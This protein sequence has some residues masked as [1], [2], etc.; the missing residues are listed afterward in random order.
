MLLRFLIL[1]A[2]AAILASRVDGADPTPRADAVAFGEAIRPFLR[3][4]CTDCHSGSAAEAGLDLEQLAADLHDPASFSRWVAVHDRLRSGEMPPAEM[5]QPSAQERTSAVALLNDSLHAENIRQ[6]TEHGRVPYRRLNRSAYEYTLRD[7]MHLPH[8]E[9]RAMLPA[10]GQAHGFDN[11]SSALSLSY[12]QLSRYLEAADVAL[13]EAIQLG[14]RPES[15]TERWLAKEEGRLANVVRQEKEAAAIGDAVGL[16]RQPN[17]AQAPWTWGKFRPPVDGVYR[18]RLK[19]FGFYWDR[20]QVLPPDRPHV[21]SIQAVQG[22]NKRTLGT[23]DVTGTPEEPAVIELE[24]YIRQGDQLE[25]WFETLDDRNMPGNKTLADYTAPGVAVEWMETI[26][27][28]VETWP[29]ESYHA[30]FGDLTIEPWTEESGLV[31]PPLPWIVSGNGKRAH[32]ERAKPNRTPLYHVVSQNPSADARR[33][34]ADFATRA[35]RRPLADGEVDDL[36]ALVEEKLEHKLCFQEAMRIGFQ[37]VLC[38]P[39]FLFLHEQPGR[40]DDYAIAS[41]LSYF[42]WNSLPDETLLT[43][44]K[45]GTLSQAEVLREQ[46][47]RML[48]D[49]KSRRFVTDLADQWLD[50]RRITVTEPDETLYPEFDRYLLDSMVRETYATVQQMLDENLSVRMLVDSDH[51]WVNERLAELYAMP[52]VHGTTMRLVKLPEN[53]PRGGLLTQ[54]S[55]LKLT[56]NG[57]TTSPVVRGAWVLDRLL[58]QP[59]PPPP[60]NIPAVEPDLRGTTTIRDQLAKHRES[61]SCMSCHRRID[62]PGFAL[63]SFDVIGGWRERYRSLENGDPV[64]KTF[65]N[66]RPVRYRLGPEVDPSGVAASGEEFDDIHGLRTILLTQQ[67]QLARNL[68]ERFLVY[69]TG[70]GIQFADRPAVEAILE[71]SAADDYGF[72]TLI[73]EVV[74]SPVFQSK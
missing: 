61:G 35:F 1:L 54:A 4:H 49:P 15:K 60:P 48:A 27:P 39:E 30:L 58:G 67:E 17:T 47:E 38:S 14:A 50:L 10:D 71:R 7:L 21:V 34:L 2:V 24:V 45:Q 59:V 51:V 29:P 36:V 68:A 9:V 46:T 43:L 41:R 20:G 72:R 3:Q 23:L 37:A 33:L 62:P 13:D 55:I 25:T 56:A 65:K 31:K 66:D 11:V 44:A 69:S 28:I 22:T 57:T 6:Q 52:D 16:L 12:V 42:L 18:I 26:G 64:N 63:E 5:P 19:A 32:R 74:Q 40:L 73:Q 8:L 53:S 70:A